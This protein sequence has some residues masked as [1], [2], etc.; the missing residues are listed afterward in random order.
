MAGSL[1]S[2][3]TPVAEEARPVPLIVTEDMELLDDLLRLCAAAGTEP[4]V[5]HAVPERRGAWEAAPLVLVGDDA[6]ERCRGAVRRSG[7]LLVGR[8]QDD[9]DV[10]RLAVEI[11]ADGVVRLPDAERFLL[12]RIADAVEGVGEPATTVGVIGGSGGAGASHLAC[13][14]AVTAAREGRRTLL[15]DGDPLGGGIDVL[16]GG[17]RT[18]GRRWPDFA[19]AR[20]RVAGGALEESLPEL[21]RLRVLS[22]DRGDS[23]VIPPEAMRSVLAAAR[24]RGGVVVVDLPRRV[25]EG[26]AEALAQL[27]LGLLVVPG[28]LR[29]VAAAARV[30][31]V[32][33]M[34]LPDLRVV[35]R[36][37]YA[38]GLDDGWVAASLGLPLAGELP[39][40]TGPP[41]GPADGAPPGRAGTPLARFCTVF[42]D[43]ALAKGGA[44]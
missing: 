23:V 4:E 29:A 39:W 22:W 38:P 2:K 31:S 12:D 28:E 18:E 17:E 7:V 37:P 3:G 9:P 16:L 15:V 34:V 43:R 27:D 13:A 40:E 5:H 33:G 35:A 25:D 8:E 6:A 20:G 19:G 14:L 41:T 42:W 21:H 30:A 11:G 24:R 10:W 36:P 32:V 44:S 26:V 1:T